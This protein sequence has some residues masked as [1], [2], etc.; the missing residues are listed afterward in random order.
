MLTSDTHLVY[1][2]QHYWINQ[3]RIWNSRPRAYSLCAVSPCGGG[4]A[5][6]RTRRHQGHL[7]ASGHGLDLVSN[8]S[9]PRPLDTPSSG[10]S[11]PPLQAQRR[12]LSVFT[13][14]RLGEPSIHRRY[15][16]PTYVLSIQACLLRLNGWFAG[17]TSYTS[18]LRPLT[19]VATH[20]ANE[21]TTRI[22]RS[23]LH[24][25]LAT[26]RCLNA[27]PAANVKRGWRNVGHTR[28]TSREGRQTHRSRA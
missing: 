17:S 13:R 2:L 15:M 16:M 14:S 22:E 12:L 23:A 18:P 8:S 21:G 20:D 11:K 3:G 4:K 10:C 28:A 1:I 9:A 25:V 5:Q 7:P 24:V 6:R 19:L 26:A 27:A